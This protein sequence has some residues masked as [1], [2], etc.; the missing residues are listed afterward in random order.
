VT[1][2]VKVTRFFFGATGVAAIMAGVMLA[3]RLLQNFGLA[4]GSTPGPLLLYVGAWF[5]AAAFV[6]RALVTADA[7]LR[8]VV[9]AI[10]WL[11]VVIDALAFYLIILAAVWIGDMGGQH[12]ERLALATAALLLGG[13][14]VVNVIAGVV[15]IP[16]MRAAGVEPANGVLPVPRRQPDPP[17]H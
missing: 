6:F 15:L 2:Q 10:L 4:G 9:Y 14:F 3:N 7:I 13:L 8:R 17:L 11:A 1:T 16:A 5:A 12:P